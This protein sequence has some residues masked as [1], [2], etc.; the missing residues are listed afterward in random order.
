MNAREINVLIVDDSPVARDLLA[1]IIQSDPQ[2]KVMGFAENGEEAINFLKNQTPDVIVMDIVMPKMNGFELTRRIMQSNPIPIVVV[3][4][5][6][7]KEEV[8]KS[9][10]AL[11]AGAIAV[12]EKPKG[13]GS[14]QY[15]DTARFV[16]DTLKAMGEVKLVA[17]KNTIQKLEP[18]ESV[19]QKP[20]AT[21]TH[22]DAAKK[23]DAIGIGASIGGPQA[24]ATVLSKLPEKFPIPIFIVQHISG[25]FVDGLVNWLNESTPLSVKIPTDGEKGLPGHVYI[26]PD[27]KNMLVDENN[28]IHLIDEPNES[29]IAPSISQ[30]FLSLANSH[31]PRSIGILLTGVGKDGV[32]ELLEMKQKGATTIVQ[33]EETCV[34]FDM[35]KHAIKLN[36]AVHVEPLNQIVNILTN[37]G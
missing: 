22:K 11:E 16:I 27:R 33:N 19:P 32:E 34:M 1:Y 14:S 4:G 37:L 5:I 12:L 24:L 6:Y 23:I 7:N 13:I 28:V 30:L 36:A 3:S 21:E 10:Q 15:L 2:L 35:P 20:K 26:A 29:N 31:G 9:F 8:N 25:G 18:P 17:G